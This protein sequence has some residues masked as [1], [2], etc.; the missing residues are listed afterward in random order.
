[1]C[2]KWAFLSKMEKH[3][4]TCYLKT[5]DTDIKQLNILKEIRNYIE[6]TYKIDSSIVKREYIK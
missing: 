2:Y 6:K 4:T 5:K 1:M 3:M